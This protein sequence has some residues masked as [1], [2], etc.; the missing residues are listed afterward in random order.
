MTKWINF[1]IEKTEDKENLNS[2]SCKWN[3]DK[4][5]LRQ[6]LKMVKEVTKRIYKD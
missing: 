1:T 4:I 6:I 5:S 3:I 2:F